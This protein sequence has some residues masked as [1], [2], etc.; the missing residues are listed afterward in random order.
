VT[1]K[2]RSTF[3]LVHHTEILA[4][5]VGLKDVQVVR[6]ERRGRDSELMVEQ[7][8]SDVRCPSCNQAAQVKERPVVHYV[9]LPVYGVPMSLGL[10]EAPLAL[11]GPEV[12]E[13]NLGARR[14]SDRGQA[15]PAHH[16]GGQVGHGPS[17]RGPHRLRGGR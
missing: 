7:V 4:A 2:A 12:S 3:V 17:R 13:E 11:S 16:P 5:Q 14:P 9:D 15:L 8:V 1:Q 10:E 6:L